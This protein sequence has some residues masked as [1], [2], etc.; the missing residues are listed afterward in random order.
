MNSITTKQEII[1]KKS[2][3][4][5]LQYLRFVLP[6]FVIMFLAACG[7]RTIVYKGTCAQQTQQF[8]DYIHSLV[9]DEL[10]PVIE[11]G[12][13]SGPTADVTKRIEELDTRVSELNTPEC[14]P[15]TQAVKDALRLY[16]LETRN[17]FATVAG[18]AVYGEGPVQGQLSKM[19]EAGWAFEK[20][21]EDLRK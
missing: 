16:M 3:K 4:A 19:Y 12:F 1:L 6:L 5:R 13:R 9:I 21:F 8:L 15:T 10:T 11:D 7:T 17:Y 18:R 14:N 2:F 20:T